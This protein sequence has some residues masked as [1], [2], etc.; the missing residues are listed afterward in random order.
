MAFWLADSR[1]G[2]DSDWIQR[3]DPRFWT[4][5]YPRPMVATIVSTGPD[6]LRVEASFLRETDLGG[7][8]W[9]SEDTID[10]PLLAYRTDRDYS[11]THLSFRWRSGGVLALDAVN[12]PT[13]TIEGRDAQGA[14]RT[15]YVRLWNY[16][17]GSPEDAVVTLPF[18]QLEGGFSLPTDADPVWPGHI[19]RMFISFAPQGYVAGSETPLSAEAEGWIEM[20][21]ITCDGERAMLE[22]GDVFLP[23]HGLAIATGYDD[24]G[25]QTPARLVRTIR[26]LG[27][28]GTVLHYVGMSH[29]FR[30]SQSSGDFLVS[31]S[32]DPLNTPT[33]TW[34]AA[35]FAACAAQGFRP[36]ASLSYELFAQHC[37]DDWMQ[38]DHLGN[39]EDRQHHQALLPQRETANTL[40]QQEHHPDHQ[41][42]HQRVLTKQ[43]PEQ[44]VRQQPRQPGCQQANPVRQRHDPAREHQRQP[45]RTSQT[46]RLGQRHDTEQQ[47]HHNAQDD[48]Q[49]SLHRLPPRPPRPRC[50]QRPPLPP[51]HQSVQRRLPARWRPRCPAPAPAIH[52]RNRFQG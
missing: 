34:H 17:Q 39:P 6:A 28:R 10:H 4:V 1:K 2:Q 42:H 7:L 20:S 47:R 19:D 8:I 5:N 23:P 48:R 31:T 40:I 44:H 49:T 45:H 33:R 43:L 26:Q 3:F 38:R 12:G 22:I 9:A 32:G 35:F 41:C 13:L 46:D 15:W 14:A 21:A 52:R 51:L 16:A 24:D 27:Y 37:P 18:S 30:L 29:F 50:R 36:I 25:V 11:H